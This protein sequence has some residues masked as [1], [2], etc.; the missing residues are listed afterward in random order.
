[1]KSN[2]LSKLKLTFLIGI[3]SFFVFSCREK[4]CMDPNAINYNPD[5]KKDAPCEY[6]DFDK[7]EM[8][9]NICDNY[10]IGANGPGDSIHNMP[11][12]IFEVG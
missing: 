3:V 4:G 6:R 7:S 8:L 9:T 2:I 5:A 1:M 12:K 11:Q 10:I